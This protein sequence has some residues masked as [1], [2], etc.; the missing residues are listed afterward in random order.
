MD[1]E[2]FSSY[3]WLVVTVIVIG[4]MIAFATPFGNHIIDQV[5]A[6]VNGFDGEAAEAVTNMG[7]AGTWGK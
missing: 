2:T 6:L 1:K 7:T 4:L 5:E 3:G